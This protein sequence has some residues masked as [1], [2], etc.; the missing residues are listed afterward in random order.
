M[1]LPKGIEN[2]ILVKVGGL[3]FLAYFVVLDMNEDAEVPMILGQPFFATCRALLDIQDGNMTLRTG[4]EEAIFK[5]LEAMKHPMEHDDTS[6]SIDDIG[7][8][9]YGCE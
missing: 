2:D 1:L 4:D 7:L 6:Y 5:L 3:V 8:I 9:I